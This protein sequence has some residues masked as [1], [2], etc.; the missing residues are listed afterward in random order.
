MNRLPWLLYTP[1]DEKWREI[2]YDIWLLL[3]VGV[4]DSWTKLF[5]IEPSFTK[6]HGPVGFWKNGTMFLM[7]FDDGQLFLYDPSTKQM[8]DLQIHGNSITDAIG[9]DAV[10]YLHGDPSFCQGRK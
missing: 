4:K 10:G 3:K 1:V 5:T 2:Q 6:I 7:A 9:H 8:T